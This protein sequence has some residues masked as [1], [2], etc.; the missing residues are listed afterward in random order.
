M[1]EIKTQWLEQTICSASDF[2]RV[3][4]AQSLTMILNATTT[5]SGTA[6]YTISHVH[7]VFLFE[8]P[9]LPLLP[10]VPP[11]AAMNASKHLYR[12]QQS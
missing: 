2:N 10:T 1:A 12:S 4:N 6:K 11:I 3:D 8:H 9:S 7:E 5:S